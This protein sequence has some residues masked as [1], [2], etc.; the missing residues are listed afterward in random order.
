MDQAFIPKNPGDHLVMPTL[1]SSHISLYS[2]L[3]SSKKMENMTKFG[4]LSFDIFSFAADQANRSGFP[5]LGVVF[6]GI[7]AACFVSGV[8]LSCMHFCQDGRRFGRANR[9]NGQ[10]PDIEMWPRGPAGDGNAVVEAAEVA[11]WI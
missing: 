10:H 6:G 9:P 7:G 4:D 5:V 11:T 2:C 1:S 8:V 3:K